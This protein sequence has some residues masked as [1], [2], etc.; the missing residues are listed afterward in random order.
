MFQKKMLKMKNFSDIQILDFYSSD[1]SKTYHLTDD[2]IKVWDNNFIKNYWLHFYRLIELSDNEINKII[3]PRL[4]RDDLKILL[5]TISLENITF[6]KCTFLDDLVIFNCS[7][8]LSISESTYLEDSV[9]VYPN[10]SN[11]QFTL[12][13]L[14]NIDLVKAE[15]FDINGRIIQTIDLSRMLNEKS[16]DI[17]YLTS[18][19]YFMSISSND[20]KSVIK[21]VKQ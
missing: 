2:N 16:I 18:G 20:A 12:K 10:P 17:R 9:V 14:K 15:I 21:L 7:A 4:N 3:I 1:F 19:M 11:G 8:A 6:S 13:K 5:T